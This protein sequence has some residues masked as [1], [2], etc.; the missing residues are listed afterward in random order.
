MHDQNNQIIF[1]RYILK[2][3]L[4]TIHFWADERKDTPIKDYSP[5]HFLLLGCVRLFLVKGQRI[6]SEKTTRPR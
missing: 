2:V 4:L 6:T 3:K 1:R 5:R